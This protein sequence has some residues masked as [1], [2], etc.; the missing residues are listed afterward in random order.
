MEV[1]VIYEVCDVY[2]SN[3]LLVLL[4]VFSAHSLTIFIT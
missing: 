3:A 2:G 1:L 4:R